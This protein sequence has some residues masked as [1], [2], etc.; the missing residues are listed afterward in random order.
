MAHWEPRHDPVLGWCLAQAVASKK[1]QMDVNLW[2][3][4]FRALDLHFLGIPE[5]V[6]SL[7]T[8]L[9][10]DSRCVCVGGVR[11]RSGVLK[12]IH[13]WKTT[14]NTVGVGEGCKCFS[15]NRVKLLRHLPPLMLGSQTSRKCGP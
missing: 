11:G 14:G 10:L 3:F 12:S 5:G 9:R 8:W 6:F 7:G 15:R 13:F 1:L 2:P 4:R